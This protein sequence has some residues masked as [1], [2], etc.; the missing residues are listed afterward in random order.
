MLLKALDTVSKGSNL[1]TIGVDGQPEVKTAA[2]KLDAIIEVLMEEDK[3]LTKS[4][5]IAKA[6]DQNPSLYTG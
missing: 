1:E 3:M 5:A 6:Y 2:G 4:A